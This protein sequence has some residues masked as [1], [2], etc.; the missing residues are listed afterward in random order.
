VICAILFP[1]EDIVVVGKLL[2]K[3]RVARVEHDPNSLAVGSTG[4]TDYMIAIPLGELQIRDGGVSVRRLERLENRPLVLIAKALAAINRAADTNVK[5][6]DDGGEESK[7]QK[8][9]KE[10][11]RLG[12]HCGLC[13]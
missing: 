12:C 7:R 10:E 2:V 9:Q 1:R 5:D 3:W 6:C 4:N 8:R 11:A 13:I